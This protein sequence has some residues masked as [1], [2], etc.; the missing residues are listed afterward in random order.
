MSRRRMRAVA[1]MDRSISFGLRGGPLFNEIRSF[2]GR[3]CPMLVSYIYGLGG[4][5]INATEIESIFDELARMSET[6]KT[7]PIYRYI[8]LRE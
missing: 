1:V 5:D 7:G 2:A 8:G 6:G 3:D 4:R